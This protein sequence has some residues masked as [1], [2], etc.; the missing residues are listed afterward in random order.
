MDT[1]KYILATDFLYNKLDATHKCNKIYPRK[2]EWTKGLSFCK[3]TELIQ[4]SNTG[5]TK[6]IHSLFIGSGY[7]R[8]KLFRGLGDIFILRNIKIKNR[9]INI[10]C[11]LD[12]NDICPYVKKGIYDGKDTVIDF[13]YILFDCVYTNIC[14][15]FEF[16]TPLYDTDIEI[17]TDD[18]DNREEDHGR[19]MNYFIGYPL[20]Y[21]INETSKEV[22]MFM[23]GGVGPIS[24][25]DKKLI[26]KINQSIDLFNKEN[27][28]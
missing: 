11:T 14:L 23:D 6:Y 9:D 20:N 16:K 25:K 24:I 15:T 13:D 22:M 2:L 19:F 3:Q 12:F 28:Y 4:I 10:K 8:I 17:N 21:D 5:N 7:L 26:K 1:S 27:P 18:Y